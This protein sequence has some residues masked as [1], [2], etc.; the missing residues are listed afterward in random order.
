MGLVKPFLLY[1]RKEINHVKS[2]LGD[3]HTGHWLESL[4]FYPVTRPTCELLLILAV[5]GSCRQVPLDKFTPRQ[6]AGSG[7]EGW[8]WDDSS[9]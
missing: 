9:T 5:F 8:L 7:E 2:F 1:F 4:A 6:G 3:D